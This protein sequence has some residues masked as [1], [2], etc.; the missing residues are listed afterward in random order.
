M[1]DPEFEKEFQELLS[2]FSVPTSVLHKL[3]AESAVEDGKPTADRYYNPLGTT[4]LY[5]LVYVGELEQ[6]KTNKPYVN[7]VSSIKP[8]PPE[9]DRRCEPEP[10]QTGTA[11]KFI[12]RNTLMA[13][14]E[15][16]L[17][18]EHR[19]V[20][21][22]IY[23]TGDILHLSLGKWNYPVKVKNIGVIFRP[24]NNF[25]SPEISSPINIELPDRLKNEY[26][27][28]LGQLRLMRIPEELEGYTF[29]VIFEVV[30]EDDMFYPVSNIT[31]LNVQGNPIER[32]PQ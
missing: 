14:P 8:T 6:P 16:I 21:N 19:E 17:F 24:P 12:S 5:K 10:E 18:V 7:L 25:V 23:Y 29:E 9:E 2:K 13:S 15:P 30:T 11:R 31:R 4:A 26:H 22:S 28:N 1:T 20:V 3:K 32:P 27:L